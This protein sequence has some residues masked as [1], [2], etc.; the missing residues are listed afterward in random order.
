[1]ADIILNEA[2]F[3]AIKA[4]IDEARAT[5]AFFG[6]L[7]GTARRITRDDILQPK[8]AAALDKVQQID[9][10]NPRTMEAADAAPERARTSRSKK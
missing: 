2:E 5:R 4:V 3:E 9:L 8:L 7:S 1:V 10:E 6:W